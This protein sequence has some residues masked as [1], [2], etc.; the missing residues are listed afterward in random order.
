MTW[1][2]GALAPS[3]SR[4]EKPR[5][6]AAREIPAWVREYQRRIEQAQSQH[7]KIRQVGYPKEA[8]LGQGELEMLD[9]NT[10]L[11]QK[12]LSELAQQVVHIIQ[13]C[14]EEKDVL[15]DEFESF[16][17][18]IEILESRIQTDTQRVDADVSGVGSQSQIQQ[19]VLQEV[20]TSINVLQSQDNQI[21][22]EANTILELHKNELDNLSKRI[23][24]N[25]SQIL[26]IKG[27][28]IGIQQSLKDINSKVESTTKVLNSI[29]LSLKEVPSRRELRDHVAKME[30]YMSRFQTMNTGMTT[31]MEEFQFSQSSHIDFAHVG[32]TPQAG[33]HP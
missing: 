23:T 17:A 27:M 6:P 32:Q 26:Y 13:A 5:S 33:K 21:V 22:T 25:S 2:G 7:E 24:D 20:R 15:E 9:N 10:S 14:N 8:E 29:K 3:M 12:Q 11:V 16:R 18:N 28:N 31:A 1:K 30:E 4:V 19:A